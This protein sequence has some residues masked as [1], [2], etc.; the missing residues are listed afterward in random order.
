MS[1]NS[2]RSQDCRE[3]LTLNCS[4]GGFFLSEVEDAFDSAGGSS[5][6][7]YLPRMVKVHH[8]IT[9]SDAA[10]RNCALSVLCNR[11]MS[12][13]RRQIFRLRFLSPERL[14]RLYLLV[15]AMRTT[16]IVRMNKWTILSLFALV[17]FEVSTVRRMPEITISATATTWESVLFSRWTPSCSS[18]L[19]VK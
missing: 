6:M 15:K 10:D 5:Q 12:F 18:H 2:A 17:T 19:N 1:L 8:G 11:Q 14:Q 7:E 3:Y 4:D 9:S 16:L 13:P